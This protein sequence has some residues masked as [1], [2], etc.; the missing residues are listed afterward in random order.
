MSWCPECKN[1]YVDGITVCSDCGCE[2]V[3]TLEEEQENLEFISTEDALLSRMKET[4]ERQKIPLSGV[5]ENATKKAEDYKSGA[6]TLVGMGA[7]GIV[8]VV[9]F[10]FGFLPVNT[11][12][13][14]RYL[15]TGVMGIMFILFFIMGVFSFKSFKKFEKTAIVENTLTDT[16][17]EWCNEYFT[18]N[19]IDQELDLEDATDELL[20]FQRSEYMKEIISK[21]FMNLK[22]DYL[23]NFVDEL[24][25]KFFDENQI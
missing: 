2:L 12:E 11:S 20:Y 10:W 13:T 15:I 1:E 3:E 14:S 22:Q 23:D 18:V 16:L 9:L 25:P 5:Y 8:F 17:T 21:N 6:Y 4:Q 19:N 24:Y 7:L